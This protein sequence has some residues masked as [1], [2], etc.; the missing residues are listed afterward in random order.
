MHDWRDS[1]KVAEMNPYTFADLPPINVCPFCRGIDAQ[2][3]GGLHGVQP[4]VA[5]LSC[6]ATGPEAENMAQAIKLWNEP[7]D[8]IERLSK[9]CDRLRAELDDCNGV[10]R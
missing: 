6:Q 10:I 2:I 9:D 3:N 7:T 5:C 1:R 4:W 8:D